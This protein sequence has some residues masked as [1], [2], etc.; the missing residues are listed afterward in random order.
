M[1]QNNPAQE[2]IDAAKADTQRA[3]IVEKLCE[4]FKAFAIDSV[5]DG[6][7]D[8]E[9]DVRVFLESA[10]QVFFDQKEFGGDEDDDE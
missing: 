3:L 2:G 8:D 6:I 9:S 1:S 5:Y 7:M 4:E 10:L